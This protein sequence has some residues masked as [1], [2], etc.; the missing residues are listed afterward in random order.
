MLWSGFVG[1]MV[2]GGRGRGQGAQWGAGT[3]RGAHSAR[4]GVAAVGKL[5]PSIKWGDMGKG[6]M[7]ISPPLKEDSRGSTVQ[8]WAE[9]QQ[10]CK[11]DSVFLRPSAPNSV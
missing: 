11:A 1:N 3:G 4:R 5:A 9:P 7:L 8:W 6:V 2:G 10:W